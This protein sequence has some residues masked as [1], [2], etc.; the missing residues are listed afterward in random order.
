MGLHTSGGYSIKVDKVKDEGNYVT[1]SV[2]SQEPGS[3]PADAALTNPY[4]FVK[5]ATNKT[6][7]IH[8][9]AP[10]LG[11]MT[12]SGSCTYSA[13]DNDVSPLNDVSFSVLHAS[14]HLRRP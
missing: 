5:I 12:S 3:C 9:L 6:I 7:I 13:S 2:V 14:N 4:Q 1:V 10:I 11:T 8:E